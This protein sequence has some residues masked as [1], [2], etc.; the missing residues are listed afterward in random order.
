MKFWKKKQET[1]AETEATYQ[2]SGE[3]AVSDL[4]QSLLGKDEITKQMAMENPTISACIN[5]IASIVASLDV[6]LYKKEDG[7]TTI[8]E[9]DERVSLLNRDTHDALT[10]TQFWKAMIE[11]YYLD[12]GG[13][14][15]INKSGNTVE[16]INYIAPEDLSLIKKYDPIYKDYDVTINGQQFYP[17]EFIK[18]LRKSKDGCESISIVKENPLLLAIAYN[19]MLFENT[20][21]K[22]GGNK[23]GFLQSAR[24]LSKEAIDYL[25][26]GFRRLYGNNSENVVVLN[27]GVTFKESSNTSVE[28]Q[29][30]ENKETNAKELAKLFPVPINMLNGKATSA[31]VDN[32]MKF[33]LTPLLKDIETS[34]NRDLLLES[35]KRHLYFA[36]DTRQINRAS[37]RERYEAYDKALKGHFLQIDEI[38]NLENLEP[39]GID[40]LELG[41][42]SVLYNPKTKEIYTPNNDAHQKLGEGGKKTDANRDKSRQHDE[43]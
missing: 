22:K 4:I 43:N 29:L 40:W 23:K 15:Y 24:K 39:L 1:R 7:K 17:F 37:I 36:F 13:Y 31:E 21:V 19:S 35:E 2:G 32:F 28:L 34:L 26:D 42:N 16:S 25:K 41:L 11:D 20:L 30:N 9:N 12:K 33:C 6:Q 18:I 27:D 38:R 5:L 14:A 3:A 10:P 8:I